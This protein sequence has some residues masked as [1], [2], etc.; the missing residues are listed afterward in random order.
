ME[1]AER[2]QDA[3]E[4]LSLKMQ[5]RSMACNV[6]NLAHTLWNFTS[7]NQAIKLLRLLASTQE[8]DLCRGVSFIERGSTISSSIL[9]ALTATD[10]Y[11][12]DKLMHLAKWLVSDPAS[13][14]AEA[15]ENSCMASSM[16]PFSSPVA[17][18]AALRLKAIG[19]ETPNFNPVT[20][21]LCPTQWR[22]EPGGSKLLA[23]RRYSFV[24]AA[25]ICQLQANGSETILAVLGLVEQS[26]FPLVEDLS[27]STAP[28]AF[29]PGHADTLR[30]LSVPLGA[31][32]RAKGVQG[33]DTGIGSAI[34]KTLAISFSSLHECGAAGS[35]KRM[36]EDTWDV[37]MDVSGSHQQG[38]G[39]E[40][41][42]NADEAG[43]SKRMG[44]D[45]W[46]VAM[47]VSGSHRL[48]VGAGAEKQGVADEAGSSHDRLAEAEKQGAAD[49]AGSSQVRQAE[50]KMQGAA[51]E[52]GSSQVRRAEAKQQGAADE[53][54]SSQVRRA[55]ALEPSVKPSAGNDDAGSSGSTVNISG[56]C[57]DTGSS[58]DSGR[59]A[60]SPAVPAEALEASVKPS[61]GSDDAG[62]SGGSG[63]GAVSSAVPAAAPEAGGKPSAG[64][65]NAGGSG[66]SGRGAVSSAV[67]AV[68]PEAG[69]KPSAGSDDAGGS[70]GSGRGA[71]SS[72]VPVAK[73][74]PPG[75]PSVAYP[76]P[77]GPPSVAY[78]LM[79][80]RLLLVIHFRPAHS[81]ITDLMYQLPMGVV[82]K[83]IMIPFKECSL[84]IIKLLHQAA[85]L[86]ASPYPAPATAAAQDAG[87]SCSR[88][89]PV[90]QVWGATEPTRNVVLT[91]NELALMVLE[92]AKLLCMSGGVTPL[93]KSTMVS[94]LKVATPEPRPILTHSVY[95]NLL[96][97]DME[98]SV[99]PTT[100]IA[101]WQVM[102]L[103]LIPDIGIIIDLGAPKS[104][105]TCCLIS[106]SLLWIPPPELLFGSVYKDLLPNQLEPSV[107]PTTGIAVWQVM[108]LDLI[109]DIGIIID[110]GAPES[111]RTCCLISSSL[112]WIPPP[113][114][115][116]GSVY[117]DLLPNQ[118][119]PSVDPTTGIAVWQVIDLDRILDIDNGIDLGAPA[120]TRTCC[121]ISSSLLWIPPPESLFSSHYKD[122]LPNQLEPSVDPTTGIA[123]WQV[124]LPRQFSMNEVDAAMR[125][126][127]TGSLIARQDEIMMA[128]SQRVPLPRQFSMN[129]VDAAMRWVYTGSLIARQDEIRLA[130]SQGVRKL[131]GVAPG[132]SPEALLRIAD[133]FDL[134]KLKALV[135]RLLTVEPT[136]TA[137]PSNAEPTNRRSHEPPK[138]TNPRTPNPRT[139]DTHE[140]A[141]THVKSHENSQPTKPP[142]QTNPIERRNH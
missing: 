13:G 82:N 22:A 42:G 55:E 118:L 61:A 39:A 117:K 96:S 140:S 102:D 106:S 23:M 93:L 73:A 3:A 130:A 74:A 48:A 34:M 95:V 137:E 54:G 67:P 57:D 71:I 92:C 52:A 81:V 114:L 123:V 6:A 12:A 77:P 63:R 89:P 49:E 20:Q 135:E 75:P 10:S 44:G 86:A 25:A 35:S 1:D 14:L 45:T 46:D 50:A 112:L 19:V 132:V 138:P 105:R 30:S 17:V 90:R 125:W 33:A 98:P 78:R 31:P 38:A 62:G 64:S 108:D 26:S 104:T 18:R 111:T 122:L 59:G 103:D 53:A 43:S 27:P 110:L 84:S 2:C 136:K 24:I 51:D 100:G 41:Q 16:F 11:P 15:V 113:E 107:D 36:G 9:S 88:A 5:C 72:E 124:P 131:R 129:E 70:G 21:M 141:D 116:F 133:H 47:D 4:Q 66:G 28:G 37:S 128:A 139:H 56:S 83:Q 76:L 109:L 99:D 121:L 142:N 97:N 94:L 79:A 126:V 69:G 85:K 40:E 87:P 60:I 8:M 68:A 119:E 127:Y 91:P 134:K 29:P 80:L 32:S 7:T 115:L 120:S 65:D 58:G 101:V